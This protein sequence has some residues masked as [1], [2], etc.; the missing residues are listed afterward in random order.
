MN[1]LARLWL[2]RVGEAYEIS[3]LSPKGNPFPNVDYTRLVYQS[4]QA[5]LVK[6]HR[7]G[8]LNNRN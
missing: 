8:D 3:S 2:L 4:S 5:A 1:K 7:L 6:H